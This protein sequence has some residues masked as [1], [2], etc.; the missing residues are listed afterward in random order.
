MQSKM[1]FFSVLWFYEQVMVVWG[2]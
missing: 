2:R 1:F